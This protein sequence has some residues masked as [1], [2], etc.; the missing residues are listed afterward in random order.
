MN[1][2]WYA[3]ILLDV[4]PQIRLMSFLLDAITRNIGRIFFTLLLAIVFLYLYAIIS[5]IFFRDQYGLGGHSACGDIIS[6]FKLHFD[7]GL[8]NPPEW[9][10]EGYIDPFIG[11]EEE[12]ESTGYVGSII[13]GSIFNFTYI[14]LINL[15]LQ[16]IISGLII[17]TFG[18]MREENEMIEN[19]IR[20]RCFICSIDRYIVHLFHKYLME[21]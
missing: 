18:E 4:I 19:D 2:Y 1:R 9:I 3:P 14:I 21:V 11:T 5:Y 13:G 12:S 20:D 15:V 7:Y 16:A 8:T 17:D 10:G 6:C